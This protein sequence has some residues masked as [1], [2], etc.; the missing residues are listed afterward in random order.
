MTT[1][2]LI[3]LAVGLIGALGVLAIFLSEVWKRRP[4]YKKAKRG[5][6]PGDQNASVL[7]TTYDSSGWFA[8]SQNRRSLTWT[9]PKDPQQYAKAFVPRSKK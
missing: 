7:H 3:W 2:T 4:S 9:V 5:V 8:A 6:A 1:S